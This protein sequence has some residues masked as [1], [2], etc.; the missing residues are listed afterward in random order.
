MSS[1]VDGIPQLMQRVSVRIPLQAIKNAGY[2]VDSFKSM[3]SNSMGISAETGLNVKPIDK[4]DYND[5]Y[6]GNVPLT[7]EYFTFDTMEPIDPYGMTRMTFDQEVNDIHGGSKLQ[8][9]NYEQSF[10]DAYDSLIN[11]LL[12]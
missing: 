3:V 4:K 10:T 12:Q 9:D 7:G 8:N 5:A 1:V 2:D 6:G 11:S